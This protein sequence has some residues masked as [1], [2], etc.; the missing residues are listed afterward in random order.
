MYAY[1]MLVYRMSVI[2][3]LSFVPGFAVLY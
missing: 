3:C 2:V 1:E